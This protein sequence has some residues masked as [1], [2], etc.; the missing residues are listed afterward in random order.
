MVYRYSTFDITSEP[1]T[2]P[3]LLGELKD[4]LRVTAG[5]FDSELTELITVAR[6]Q[7]ESDTERRLI[8]QTIAI[9]M[10]DFPVS[11][12]M[13]LRTAPI[14]AVTSITYTDTDGASQTFASSKYNT[15]FVSTPPRV[16]LVD[17]NW[18]PAVENSP[19]AAVVTCTCGYGAATAVPVEAKLAIAEWIKVHWGDCGGSLDR[20]EA[21]ANKLRWSA[22]WQEA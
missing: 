20:Y 18:W 14:S 11:A 2:E 22:H 10:D 13:E 4:R 16:M 21:L 8:T 9:R 5:D 6:R 12:I 7:F 1:A 3:I 15:D 19:N 17:G